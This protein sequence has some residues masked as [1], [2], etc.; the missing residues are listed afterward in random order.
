MQTVAET[1]L[2]VKQADALFSEAE[3]RELIDFLAVNPLLGDEIPGAGGVR[4]LRIGA[5]GKGKRGGARVIYYWY[6]EDAPL[7]ALLVYGKNENVDLKPEEAKAVAA[8]AKAIK[9][10]NRSRSGAK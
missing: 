6:S 5:K 1:S 3:R 7:Y 9:A 10:A 4:K 8:F 2:F